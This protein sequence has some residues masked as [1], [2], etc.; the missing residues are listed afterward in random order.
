MSLL[1]NGSQS[2]ATWPQ[3]FTCFLT[4]SQVG[5][6]STAFHQAQL[7]GLPP[8]QLPRLKLAN[9]PKLL[10]VIVANE[11]PHIT[12]RAR[13]DRIHELPR[14]AW[15]A[16]VS[17]QPGV[18]SRSSSCVNALRNTA[19]VMD[20]SSPMLPSYPDPTIQFTAG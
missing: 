14:L 12:A 13:I 9:L 4:R 7:N 10:R 18:L 15:Q 19:F 16:D 17:Q 6:P 11:A 2:L 3:A 20:L 5:G 8:L 1:Q